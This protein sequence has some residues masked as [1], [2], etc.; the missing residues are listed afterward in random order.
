MRILF[1]FRSWFYKYSDMILS[2]LYFVWVLDALS[3][4]LLVNINGRFEI[5]NES[6]ILQEYKS[7][8]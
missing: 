2:E 1:V 3:T 5:S 7:F 6:F 4:Y 8:T